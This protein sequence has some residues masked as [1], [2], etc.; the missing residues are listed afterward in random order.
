MDECRLGYRSFVN[1]LRARHVAFFAKRRQAVSEAHE[2]AARDL[3]S[4][5]PEGWGGRLAKLLP[6]HARHRHHLS[7]ASSQTLAIGSWPCCSPLP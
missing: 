2:Y 3:E 1:E 6:E 4:A 5:L 7:G